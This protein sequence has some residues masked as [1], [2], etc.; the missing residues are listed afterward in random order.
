MNSGSAGANNDSGGIVV[1]QDGPNG[2]LFGWA[3][4]AAASGTGGQR[5]GVK[6]NFSPSS[7][8]NFDPDAYMSAVLKG[9]D[10]T[11]TAA[12]ILALSGGG[13][14]GAGYNRKG[15]IYVSSNADDIWIYS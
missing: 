4:A 5:W 2:E 6:T 1:L 10:N 7:T 14:A 12:S 9:V 11:N 3:D 8:G 13:A 15:N